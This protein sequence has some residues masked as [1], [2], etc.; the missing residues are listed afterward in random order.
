MNKSLIGLK[1]RSPID[2]GGRPIKKYHVEKRDITMK[3][4]LN[5]G[6][7]EKVS[8]TNKGIL[9]FT[10]WGSYPTIFNK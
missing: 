9:P 3:A 8:W 5:V 2:D 1:W 10:A 7:V 4:W 6:S